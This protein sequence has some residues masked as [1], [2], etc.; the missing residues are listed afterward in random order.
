MCVMTLILVM[1]SIVRYCC[2][3]NTT[4]YNFLRKYLI[5][6]VNIKNVTLFIF[7]YLFIYGLFNDTHCLG[8]CNVYW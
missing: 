5:P 1:Q 4:D 7:I 8:M 6:A 3:N 2:G